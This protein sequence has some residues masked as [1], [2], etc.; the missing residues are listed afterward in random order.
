M[1]AA[2]TFL[3]GRRGPTDLASKSLA[4]AQQG[5]GRLLLV[6]GEA[7]V[8]KSQLARWAIEQ[9]QAQGLRVARGTAV[10]DAGAP[11]FWPW[12]RASNDLPELEAAL[13]PP[14]DNIDDP[15]SARFRLHVAVTQALQSSAEQG[16]LLVLEDIHWADRDSLLLLRHI[17][18]ELD[19]SRI[20]VLAT[21]RPETSPSLAELLPDLVRA[22]EAR[23]IA[24]SG[25]E[26]TDVASWMRQTPGTS[27]WVAHASA[28]RDLTDGNPLFLRLLTEVLPD[29]DTAQPSAL[30]NLT[31]QRPDLAEVVLARFNRLPE[32][33]RALLEVASVMAEQL[34]VDVLAAA[35]ARSGEEV[36]L[37]LAQGLAAGVLRAEA[38]EAVFF[39]H[40]LVRDAI[41]GR[42]SPTTRRELHAG[43]AAALENL[44]RPVPPGLV[45][46]HWHRAGAGSRRRSLDWATRAARAA[47]SAFAYDEAV[48]FAQQAAD[49]AAELGEP[50]EDQ[51]VLTLELA[52]AQF[53]AER[54]PDAL[55]CCLLVADLAER[56][57]RPDLGA[58]AALVITGVG[59]AE[60]YRVLRRISQRALELLPP[61]EKVMRARLLAQLAV[62]SAEDEGGPAAMRLSADALAA[63]ETS[64]DQEA[65]LD[66]LAAR[67]LSIA[68]PE[69]VHERIQLA[70]RAIAIGAQAH[71]PI[72]ALWGHLWRI[73]AA[74]QLGDLSTADR[75]LA[76]IDQLAR[77]RKSALARWHH[78]RIS[79][80][81]CALFGD[82]AGAHE[83]N[84]AAMWLAR[85]MDDVTT[86]GLYYAFRT[87][88]AIVRGDP[89]EFPDGILEVMRGA[90][91]MPLIQIGLVI[92]LAI[93]GDRDAAVAAFEEFRGL[94][95]QFPKGTRWAGTMGQ[96]GVAAVLLDDSEV[97]GAVYELLAPSA[98]YCSGDG[99]GSIFCHGSNAYGLGNLALTA[100]EFDTALRHFAD[101]VAVNAGLG[102]RP[103]TALSRLGWAKALHARQSVAGNPNHGGGSNEEIPTAHKLASQAMAEFTRLN[104]PGPRS[105]AEELL[106]QL[107]LESTVENPLSDRE[108]EVARLVSDGL[109]NREI[110]GQ[111][112]LSERTVESHV[113]SILNKLGVR[114]RTEIATWTVLQRTP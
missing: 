57:Q 114:S 1:P 22:P 11:T 102:A 87:Q 88:L 75:H 9:A 92:W 56:C 70:E 5:R 66:A 60:V 7:G 98:K 106:R 79:A 27:E 101:A 34:E 61:E 104:M 24:L 46:A 3:V 68:V 8:G 95:G 111:L 53:A 99:S 113:R 81:R 52:R 33:V 72:A 38:K 90:P 112:F 80:A 6:S 62:A 23:L 84:E 25:L 29:T 19:D 15:K 74:F 51:A 63:A 35:S 44:K 64:G 86:F 18:A 69:T 39:R 67:H 20:L 65:I 89:A 55:E 28:L 73:D 42:L 31:E 91:P 10:D 30:E 14:S 4:Q 21:F 17:A 71:R 108:S 36:S 85:Q 45:A 58:Q 59:S 96:I 32:S 2:T 16:L 107:R 49:C 47:E 93:T 105:S 76:E 37:Q 48:R 94:P 78:H 97:A 40:A 41:Y 82:F 109:S 26:T 13:T 83:H 50:V 12:I 54:V 100:G 103:F 77:Q 110:A 43:I